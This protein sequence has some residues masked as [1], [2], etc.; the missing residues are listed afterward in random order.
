MP[1]VVKQEHCDQL[2][3]SFW[4]TF[5]IRTHKGLFLRHLRR[6][7]FQPCKLSLQCYV[8]HLNLQYTR[9]QLS[10]PCLQRRQLS[11]EFVL[12][13]V[14]N[15]QR[16]HNDLPGCSCA[17]GSRPQTVASASPGLRPSPWPS[18]RVGGSV[19]ARHCCHKF[20]AEPD[21][22]VW[23]HVRPRSV[24]PN[25]AY[26]IRWCCS[27]ASAFSRAARHSSSLPGTD[28]GP[29]RAYRNVSN[30]GNGLP[31]AARSSSALS[32]GRSY[33]CFRSSHLNSQARAASR[34][35]NRVIAG[36]TPG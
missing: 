27:C 9:N 20:V 24:Q 11:P 36:G 2:C 6:L 28:E 34:T 13:T 17:H 33:T 7:L 23:E 18:I 8:C 1:P 32:I 16:I 3:S 5:L 15:D 29:G 12:D 31:A 4:Q 21:C 10:P 14:R 25:A 22:S 35:V 30:A 26:R 19:S